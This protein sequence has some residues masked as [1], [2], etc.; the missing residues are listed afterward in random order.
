MKSPLFES[1]LVDLTQVC[2]G[3]F[4]QGLSDLNARVELPLAM[5]SCELCGDAACLWRTGFV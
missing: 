2:P 1:S 5:K 4:S 3:F